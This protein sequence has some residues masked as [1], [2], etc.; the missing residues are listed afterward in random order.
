LRRLLLALVLLPTPAAGQHAHTP[1]APA[2]TTDPAIAAFL[3]EVRAATRSYRSLDAAIAAG[4]RAMGPAMPNMGEHWVNPAIAVRRDIDPA[5]PAV[6]TYVRVGGV[7]VLTGVAY[8]APVPPGAP[9]PPPP[10]PGAR[11]HFHSGDLAEEA[12]GALDHAGGEG[13]RMA[14]AH[15]WVW[16]PNP[17]GLFAPDNWALPYA[18]AGLP[19]PADPDPA[20]ARAV[21]LMGDGISF[22]AAAVRHAAGPGAWTDAAEEL[23]AGAARRAGDLVAGPGDKTAEL[24][25]L[26]RALWPAVAA[27]VPAQARDGVAAFGQ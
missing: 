4:Y 20:A 6:L 24:A 25:A 23:L 13:P 21:S 3:T 11:W 27:L 1:P 9:V 16:V 15:A 2:D 8:I 22:Y 12:F 7:P 10:A 19:A 17:D 14:M 26:W 18:A 5:R